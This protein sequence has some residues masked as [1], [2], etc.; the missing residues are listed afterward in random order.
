MALCLLCS[1]DGTSVVI[2]GK[3]TSTITQQPVIKKTKIESNEDYKKFFNNFKKSFIVP[4]LLE[5]I[6]PQGMCYDETN[7]CFLISGYY[8]DEKLPSMIIAVDANSGDFVGAYPL[9][10]T[11]GDNY[12]GH[13]GGIA[14]SQNT[15]YI[16]N[17]SE[18][19]TLPS[20][21]IKTTKNGEPITFKG[22][23][24]LNTLGSFACIYNNILWVGDFIESSNEA[25]QQV[26]TITT[27]SSGE[28]FYA[29]CEGYILNEGLPDVKN[30]N[31]ESNGYI[32]DYMLAIPE[33][34]QGMAFTKTDKIIFSTSY[35]RKNNSK[36][37]IYN[38][39]LVNEKS[40]TIEI[41]GKQVDVIA[42]SS[43]ELNKEIIAPPMSEGM[44]NHPEGI[45]ILFESGA[46]KYRNH[47]GK[48]PV[49]SVFV[50]TIE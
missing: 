46:K 8:E 13:A 15:V 12:Y 21:N 48:N 2:F 31:S 44:A 17:N 26:D 43:D 33:Q 16:T 7:D 14:S 19:Y 34:V 22:K 39:V 50:T 6:I 41:D 29:Y 42:C 30:I 4:G 5:G 36:L 10:T 49:D 35:G 45:Y 40:N 3:I 9:K 37:Y 47:G 1:C 27:L 24:K 25:R 18:C 20:I 38:D 28:T 23:F 11:N 32:P